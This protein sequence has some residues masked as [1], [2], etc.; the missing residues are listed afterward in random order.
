MA[1]EIYKYYLA[2]YIE[3]IKDTV[4]MHPIIFLRD[5]NGLFMN[6]EDIDIALLYPHH[7][8]TI[9]DHHE[10]RKRYEHLK[11]AIN[12]DD[13]Y[14]F[15]VNNPDLIN[16]IQDFTSRAYEKVIHEVNL[17]DFLNQIELGLNWHERINDYRA[18]DIGK[19]FERLLMYRKSIPKKNI[20]REETDLILLSAIYDMDATKLTDLADCYIYYRNILDVYSRNKPLD[21]EINLQNLI[22]SVFKY[23][24]AEFV[25]NKI[26]NSSFE[27]FD[28]AIWISLVLKQFNQLTDENLQKVLENDYTEL[29]DLD[30]N[31]LVTLAERVERK[32][33]KLYL[34]KRDQAEK[35]IRRCDISLYQKAED[36][37]LFVKENQ[38]SPTSI[39][40]GIKS[41]LK[42]FNLEGAKKLY[43]YSFEDLKEVSNIVEGIPYQIKS[44]ISAQT[45][46]KSL[47][48]WLDNI[49]ELEGDTVNLIN[50]IS[51]YN[52]WFQ[53]FTE[54]L[55]NLEY[56]LSEI[57]Y[58]LDTESFIES[59][60]YGAL[61][62]RLNNI[63]NVFRKSFAKY[64]EDHYSHWFDHG[65]EQPVLNHSVSK[66]VPVETDKVV[67][68]I[69]DGMRYDAWKKVV[70]P[71]FQS[72]FG[73]R[74]VS[75]G[76]SLAML[77]SIT[78]LSREAIYSNIRSS[79][80][81]EINYITKSESE[82]RQQVVR[83]SLLMDKRINIL[84][85][86]MF[87]KEGH[88]STQG[89]SVFYKRQIEV[90]EA[91]IRE[92]INALPE[93][94]HIVI[95]SDHGFAKINHYIKVDDASM[96]KS[97]FVVSANEVP[98][99]IKIGDYKLS[100]TDKGYY[101]GGGERD[102]YSHGG[103]SF[104]E[105]ILP[106][107]HIKPKKSTK[108]AI[109]ESINDIIYK[110][111]VREEEISLN[112]SLN[113]KE[114]VILDTLSRMNQLTTRDIES[115]LINKFGEAG[116]VDGMMKR[117]NRKLTKSGELKLDISSAGEII[118][119]KLVR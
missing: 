113:N 118:V 57:R 36:Y 82:A 90:F 8:Y 116:M 68:A 34:Q 18:I 48:T 119:Y 77:P 21:V 38:N 20:S 1:N 25:G 29:K 73:E 110:L 41:V 108:M 97:R 93:D 98:E 70:E 85:F 99:S 63:L 22:I 84:I 28:D 96:V 117:L 5:Y 13:Y 65:S 89:L 19:I 81:S 92:L 94:V 46:L 14:I 83:D 103:A 88:S 71:Y 78:S 3:M 16:K 30:F 54:K 27:S 87:D 69:F 72:L 39:V 50:S 102:L 100:Y 40:T 66:L 33:K 12:K 91:S 7:V 75:Y 49:Y 43:R 61:E 23:F 53:L 64:I 52:Q 6:I 17:K 47:V 10:F 101:Y 80:G 51:D 11:H 35:L 62:I 74:E 112:L 86:N 59:R 31:E 104:E 32:E 15:I 37:V 55:Y 115:M 105:V 45:F 9:E 109:N 111:I 56:E 95:A 67:F 60:R 24:H 79:Y 2:K 107:I 76:H 106:F 42:D 114:K 4:P 58:T 44:V 26:R